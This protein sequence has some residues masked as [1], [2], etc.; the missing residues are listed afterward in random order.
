MS[1]N[2]ARLHAVVHGKVQGV[3]FRHFTWQ[4]ARGLGLTGWVRNR[5]NRTVELVAEGPRN[6]LEELLE[7]IRQGPSHAN[8]SQVDTT[9]EDYQGEF[10]KFKIRMTR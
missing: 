1:E 9:W 4:A 2:N 3:R 5:F 8:V 7:V 6:I 10:S